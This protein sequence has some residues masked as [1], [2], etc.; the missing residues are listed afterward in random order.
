MDAYQNLTF[1][2]ASLAF[3]ADIYRQCELCAFGLEMWMK[4]HNGY[5]KIAGT[6]R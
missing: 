1:H 4:Q 3:V 5:L 2:T 6:E